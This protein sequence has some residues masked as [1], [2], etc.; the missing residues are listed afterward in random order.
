VLPVVGVL[1]VL[2][3]G[4]RF[5]F[6]DVTTDAP[7][8]DTLDIDV[9]L[10]HDEDGD[11]VI[12]SED[13]C[14]HIADTLNADIDGDG[15]GDVCDR[16]PALARQQWKLFAPMTAPTLPGIAPTA[17]AWTMNADDWSYVDAASQVQ[18]IR[19][20]GPVGDVDAWV[21]IDVESLGTGGIQAAIIL[22]GTN[23]P[24]WY[25]ELYDDTSGGARVS[26][27]EFTGSTYT[28]RTQMPY[29]GE[30]P[31]GPN[32][33]YLSATVGGSHTLQVGSV[34]TTFATPTHTAQRYMIFAFGHHN[35]RVRYLAIITSQ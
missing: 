32:D 9:L 26:I 12:D 31:L 35:G 24:Y 22:N 13:F 23:V 7:R 25:G 3:C 1:A 33:L 11:G 14:P 27:A 16:E 5:A 4:C 15:V 6:D 18:L 34:M 2:A 19:D 17:G 8:V 29:G 28:A 10:G 20:A 21:G 30:F